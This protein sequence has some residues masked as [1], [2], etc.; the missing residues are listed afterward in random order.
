MTPIQKDLFLVAT[1]LQTFFASSPVAQAMANFCEN[2]AMGMNGTSGTIPAFTLGAYEVGPIP[3]AK[4][5]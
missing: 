5:G 2:L 3:F 1:I 4:K